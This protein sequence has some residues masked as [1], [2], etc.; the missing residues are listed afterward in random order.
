LK[1]YV[2]IFLLVIFLFSAS[3]VKELLKVNVLVEHFWETKKDDSSISFLH[4]LVMHYITDDSN[5]K[6]DGRDMQLPFK[7]PYSFSAH[8]SNTFIPTQPIEQLQATC[9][10]ECRILFPS[11]DLIVQGYNSSVWRPPQAS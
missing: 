8:S 1:K 11:Q 5:S 10:A 4:F 6:D 3:D 2:S 7:S 9:L